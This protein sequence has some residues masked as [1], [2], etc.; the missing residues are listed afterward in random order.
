LKP[1]TSGLWAIA[2]GASMLSATGCKSFWV[3]ARI[4]NRSGEPIHELEVDYPSASF[5]T[6]TLAPGATMQY[7]FQIRGSGPLQVQ[8]TTAGGK[9][10][11][12]QGLNLKEH[13]QGQVIIRLLPQDKVDFLPA[14]QP[15]S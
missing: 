5:G 7:R 11:R 12:A 13:Q 10:A 6:N 15:A 2:L 14:L 3:D 8:Y 4:E 9:A 1:I